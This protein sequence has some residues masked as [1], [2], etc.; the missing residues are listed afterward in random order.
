MNTPNYDKDQVN[1]AFI[2]L[3]KRLQPAV[4][5]E[6]DSNVIVIS[7]FILKRG[8]SATSADDLLF[9]VTELDTKEL[10]SWLKPPVAPAPA[11]KKTLAQQQAEFEAK[12]RERLVE[13]AKANAKPFDIAARTKAAEELKTK[14]K[15]QDNAKNVLNHLLNSWSVNS[16]IPGR[17]DEG[18]S[19]EGR[20]VL[21]DIKIARGKVVDYVLT[22]Q[23]IQRLFHCDTAQQIAAQKDDAVK[24]VLAAANGVKD[25]KAIA[26]ERE[27][28][29]K[30]ERSFGV[31]A[32]ANRTV[33]R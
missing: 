31:G 5:A 23:V 21:S 2:E 20:K 29:L 24:A 3:K 19:A 14:E 1:A 33:Y 12:E 8:L 26:A 25:E 15:A 30:E 28:R 9:A 17:I 6:N 18:K 27:R 13:E 11:P 7:N 32:A 4:L 16:T 22:L 10:I